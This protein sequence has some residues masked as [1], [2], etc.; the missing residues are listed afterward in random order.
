[1]SMIDDDNVSNT[2]GNEH[3]QNIMNARVSRRSF[4][5]GGFAAAAAASLGGVETLLRAVPAAA[6]ETEEAED[7]ETKSGGRNGRRPVL[8]FDSVSVSSA[9]DVVVPKGYTAEVLI[10]WGDPISN[11]PTFKQDASNTAD[12]QARQWGMHNDGL[13]YFPIIGSQRGLIVQNNEYTDDGL[14]FPDG[15]NNWSAEKTRKSLNAHGVSIIE[16]TKRTGFPWDWRRRHGKWDVV[17][18]SPF[19]RR[20]TGMTPIEIGGPAAGDPRLV[21]SEDPT[22]RRVLGT[23]NNCAMGFT[24]WGTYLACEENFNGYFRKNGL[25]TNLEKRYGITA[26]GSGYLW[27]TTDK[28]F[29]VDEEP[30]EPNRFG[31]VVEIDPFR[32]NSTPMK[33]TALGRIKHEGALVQ[34]ARNGKIV[35]YMGDDERNEYMYRYVS[36]LPWR[37]AQAQGI[38]PLDDGILSV[39]KFHP[40]GV[41]EWLSLTPDNPRLAGWSLNDILINT[42]GAADAAGATMMDRPE[43]IDTFPKELTAIATLTNNSRRGT[44][45]P[46]V[47]NPDG[48]TSA[49]SARPPADP[50]NPRPNNNYGH[51]IRWYC[52]QDWT[53]PTFGWD[54]FAL[55]GDP[56]NPAHGSTIFGDKYGSPDGIYVDRSGLIWI[57]TDVSTSTI[58]AGAYVGFGNNQMLAAHPETRETRRFLVGPNQCEITGVMMTP[59]RRTMFVG[60]QHPGERPDDQPGDPLNPKQF[61]AWPDG[62]DGSRPRSALIVITKDDGGPIGS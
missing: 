29:R 31:W 54:I 35:V 46:S 13:V 42:R 36:N 17:R 57:Q 32:P 1:M 27:H 15:V 45:P 52:R 61:S 28:R 18:P 6:Q 59:D 51:I 7:T 53:E 39:A 11:G 41:G 22:G 3:F 24:P 37:Q 56:V 33:R 44:T 16:I 34:E 50:A 58:N 12:E 48:T 9:D 10:A 47:N 60:I 40:D 14:L 21:T 49:G 62:P 30:N 4:L 26:A 2:S 38:N 43:W 25:Q 23:L 20:I 55:C 19:A 8:G 5:T